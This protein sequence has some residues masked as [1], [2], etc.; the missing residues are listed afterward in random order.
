MCLDAG[1]EALSLSVAC[2]RLRSRYPS[3]SPLTLRKLPPSDR[4]GIS[5]SGR[6]LDFT[7]LLHETL[8]RCWPDWYG[9]RVS[10]IQSQ[11]YS[12]MFIRFDMNFYSSVF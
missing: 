11:H 12:C 3:P 6:F 1:I 9:T 2:K 4:K 5:S 8:L 10:K 7:R